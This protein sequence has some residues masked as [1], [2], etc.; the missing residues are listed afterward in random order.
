MYAET[1]K[2]TL[3]GGNMVCPKC[4][5]VGILNTVLGK[6]FYYCKT[7]KEEILLEEVQRSTYEGDLDLS[8]F[9]QLNSDDSYDPDDDMDY[10]DLYDAGSYD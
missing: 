4:K 1:D 8:D 7:C 10:N 6:D 2:P 5:N 9:M 3:I